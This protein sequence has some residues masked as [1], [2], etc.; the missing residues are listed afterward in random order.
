MAVAGLK[1]WE[2]PDTNLSAV[3]ATGA[4]AWVVTKDADIVR[5]EI[6]ASAVTSG[7]VVKIQGNT[8]A[9]GSGT[10]YDIDSQTVAANKAAGDLRVEVD[11]T[12]LF[13]A[14]RTNVSSR[15]DG[16]FTTKIARHF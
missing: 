14:V 5:F 16:T 12:D 6:V 13:P 7:G 4:G 2:D 11:G 15:T 9:D 10:T 1:K 8:K 3:T